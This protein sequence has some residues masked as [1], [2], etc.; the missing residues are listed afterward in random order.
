MLS[1]DTSRPMFSAVSH[2]SL[3]T[4]TFY[5][6][7]SE[8]YQYWNIS[9]DT[10]KQI[11]VR[12]FVAHFITELTKH[13]GARQIIAMVTSSYVIGIENYTRTKLYV[14]LFFLWL[15]SP[16]NPGHV[17][18]YLILYTVGRTPW[19]GDQPVARPLP[20]HDNTNRINTQI[21][22]PWVGFESTIP[23]FERVKTGH[24]LDRAATVIGI[25]MCI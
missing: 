24:A 5:I 19:K 8:Y 20:T 14:L 6:T 1:G 18:S 13:L 2:S 4:H 22:M 3:C 23:V 21:S 11:T 16:S 7:T 17:F 15:Y 25:Y 10:L 12:S 9:H